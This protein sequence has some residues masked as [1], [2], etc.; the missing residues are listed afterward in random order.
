MS[1]VESC[2]EEGS[3]YLNA[4]SYKHESDTHA[5]RERLLEF[6]YGVSFFIGVY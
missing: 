5:R 6:G 1:S 2:K 4:L 3:S